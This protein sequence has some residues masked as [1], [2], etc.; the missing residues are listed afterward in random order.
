MGVA[1]DL[2]ECFQRRRL[3]KGLVA[4]QAGDEIDGFSDGHGDAKIEAHP[5][6]IA[7]LARDFFEPVRH[8][9]LRA[10]VELHVGIDGKAVVASFAHAAPFS[11][12]LHE[13]LINAECVLLA[14]GTLNGGEPRFNFLDGRA[15]HERFST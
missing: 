11:V 14:N 10:Q 13:A 7:G 5:F 2:F 6:M 12:G 1:M 4:A 8:V 9:R 3:G 15:G